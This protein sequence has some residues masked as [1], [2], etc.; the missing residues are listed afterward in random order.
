MKAPVRRVGWWPHQRV[1][2]LSRIRACGARQEVQV[3]LSQLASQMLLE[4]SIHYLVCRASVEPH[5]PS[6]F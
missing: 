4:W 5:R 6:Y 3:E 1:S 2:L